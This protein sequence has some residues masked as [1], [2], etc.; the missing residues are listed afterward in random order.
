MSVPVPNHRNVCGSAISLLLDS[1]QNTRV[2]WQRDIDFP[3]C[4]YIFA[5][6][7]VPEFVFRAIQIEFG[8]GI[9]QRLRTGAN[10]KDRNVAAISVIGPGS[11][12]HGLVC[13]NQGT[14]SRRVLINGDNFRISKQADRPFVARK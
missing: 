7:E 12:D 10:I 1:V 9:M 11:P 14:L 3:G 5:L 6:P 13:A 4:S 2:R 8:P